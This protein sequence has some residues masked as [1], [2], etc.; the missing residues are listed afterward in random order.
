MEQIK[1]IMDELSDVEKEKQ[2]IQVQEKELKNQLV[3]LMQNLKI[4]KLENVFIKVNLIGRFTRKTVDSEKL[5]K[6]FPEVA[7]AC[8]K[9]TV[10]EPFV[11]VTVME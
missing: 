11:K 5:R 1:K 8:T 4:S 2:R 10:I 3:D 9:S 6:Q 7:K